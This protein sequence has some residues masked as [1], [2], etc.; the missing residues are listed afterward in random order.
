MADLDDFFAKKDKK[1]K[2]KK[3]PK[4]SKANTDV[5]AKNLLENERKEENADKKA[6]SEGVHVPL[7]RFPFHLCQVFSLGARQPLPLGVSH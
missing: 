5:L 6:A 4:Y 7:G 3:G 2:Q 1:K